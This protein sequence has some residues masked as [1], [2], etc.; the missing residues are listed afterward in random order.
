MLGIN[1]VVL[2]GNLQR[3]AELRTTKNGTKV[4]NFYLALNKRRYA[5]DGTWEDTVNYIKCA[6]FGREAEK[7]K[8][9][10]KGTPVL[11]TG[12]LYSNRYTTN[13]VTHFEVG[14]NA[15]R[16]ERIMKSEKEVP[17]PTAHEHEAA[18]KAR[19]E[20]QAKEE[21]EVVEEP[22]EDLDDGPDPDDLYE[23]ESDEL[24]LDFL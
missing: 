10:V 8:A 11:V 20:P 3:D 9:L 17:A 4:L 13:G 15:S 1:Q 14:V 12:S 7:N 2:A 6:V 18:H 22:V 21:V 16:I 19:K 24:D 5:K 23:D